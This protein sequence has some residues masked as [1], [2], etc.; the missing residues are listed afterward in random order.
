MI[1]KWFKWFTSETTSNCFGNKQNV[2]YHQKIALKHIL[3][4]YKHNQ[5]LLLLIFNKLSK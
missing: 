3:S 5:L 4:I 2:C 1:K